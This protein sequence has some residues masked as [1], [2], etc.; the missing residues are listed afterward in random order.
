MNQVVQVQDLWPLAAYAAIILFLVIAIIGLSYILGE[1][2]TG[3][4]SPASRT[5]PVLSYRCSMDTV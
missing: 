5:N 1:R 2:H 3:Q 4:D